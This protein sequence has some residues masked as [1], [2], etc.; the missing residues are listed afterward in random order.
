T[1]KDMAYEAGEKAGREAGEKAGREAGKKIGE[2]NGKK[3]GKVIAFY[4][5]GLSVGEIAERVG[6]TEDEVRE[7]I[8]ESNPSNRK[9][10]R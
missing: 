7:I 10:T 3:I 9:D 5:V 4:E 8:G 1:V 6:I 2:K